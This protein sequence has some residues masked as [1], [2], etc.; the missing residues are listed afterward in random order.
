MTTT[1]NHV[2]TSEPE[3]A[4]ADS[5]T[6][7]EV[8]DEQPTEQTSELFTPVS[9][10]LAQHSASGAIVYHGYFTTEGDALIAVER[11]DDS[12]AVVLGLLHHHVRHSPNGF[13]WGYPGSG[14]AETA[15]CLLLDAV[16]DHRCAKCL[17]SRLIVLTGDAPGD[18]RPY[19]AERDTRTDDHVFSCV[20]CDDGMRALPYQ[21]FKFAHVCAW[22]GEWWMRRSDIRDWLIG[23]GVSVS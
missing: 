7:S 17:G 14:P 18:E 15:R 8:P 21:E 20:E 4:S 9:G 11:H 5:A 1:E 23:K 13:Q 19:D 16:D 2:H 3:P 6:G 10:A 12:G 22:D